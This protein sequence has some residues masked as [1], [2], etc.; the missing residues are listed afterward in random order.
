MSTPTPLAR[1]IAITSGKG[2][3]GKTCVAANLACALA[4]DGKRVLVLDADLGLAN[5]DIVLNLQPAATLQ[6]V[7]NGTHRVEQV[8]LDGPEGI[9]V[10]PAG[11]GLI[12]SAHL[13]GDMRVRLR[14]ELGKLVPNFDF[15]LI[16]T[17]AG[18]SDVVLYTASL[19]QEVLMVVTPEPTS[20]SDAYATIKVLAIHQA[21]AHFSLAINQNTP[22]RSGEVLVRQL[23]QIAD[24]FLPAL[25]GHSVRLECAGT[26][27]AD[28][29]VERSVRARTPVII[30]APDSGAAQ[31]LRDLARSL[32]L[33]S[34]RPRGLR[35]P[36]E[37]PVTRA[38]RKAD[39]AS[40]A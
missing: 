29:A 1:T 27:P 16:D 3:V 8:M 10:L 28:A 11:S 2:G 25:L 4:R 38:V 9:R 19:A 17:G 24:R 15:L 32:A 22:G 6:D 18:I 37:V 14:R 13:T 7:L 36:A 23:Q 30:D 21:R 31:A 12:E 20:L 39:T 34:E 5:L 33:H 26:I 35:L 40:V